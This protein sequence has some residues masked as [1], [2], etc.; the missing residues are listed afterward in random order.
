MSLH[1]SKC[2]IVGNHMPRLINSV[3]LA[4]TD[5]ECWLG[6]FGVFQADVWVGGGV[7]VPTLPA[8]PLL[9]ALTFFAGP[10][11]TNCDLDDDEKIF[12]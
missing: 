6:N 11:M 1:L 5:T 7:G 9:S 8:E 2:H 3:L 12:S 4:G 10:I